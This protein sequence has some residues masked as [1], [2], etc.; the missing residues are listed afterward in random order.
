MTE[1]FNN[2]WGIGYD[3][4]D[5]DGLFIFR[6]FNTIELSEIIFRSNL[7]FIQKL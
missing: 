5:K 2:V 4:T 3:D 6:N 1:F 7:I